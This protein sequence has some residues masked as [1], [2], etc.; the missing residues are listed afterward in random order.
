MDLDRKLFKVLL[1]I[2]LVLGIAVFTLVLAASLAR[3]LL[4]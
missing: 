1:L 3:L 4:E 2:Y